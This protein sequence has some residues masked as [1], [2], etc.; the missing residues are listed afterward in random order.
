MTTLQP[1]DMADYFE[2]S[3]GLLNGEGGAYLGQEL[4]YDLEGPKR[5]D[6][7]EQETHSSDMNGGAAGGDIL[8]RRDVDEEDDDGEEFGQFTAAQIKVR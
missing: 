7:L 3:N 6:D 2:R 8:D 4:A 5:Q 1:K